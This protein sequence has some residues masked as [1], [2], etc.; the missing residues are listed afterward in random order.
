MCWR[1]IEKKAKRIYKTDFFMDMDAEPQT[2]WHVFMDFKQDGFC[3]KLGNQQG[4][5]LGYIEF[6]HTGNS[7]V[8][9]AG[10]SLYEYEAVRVCPADSQ[11]SLQ[12]L[13]T[14]CYLMRWLEAISEPQSTETFERLPFG[15]DEWRQSKHSVDLD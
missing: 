1:E 9:K 3:L 14:Q 12:V 2:V 6:Q 11:P 10:T 5:A 8:S 13:P 4:A 7:H 15:S